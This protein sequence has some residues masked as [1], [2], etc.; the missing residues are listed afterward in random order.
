MSFPNINL[1]INLKPIFHICYIPRLF[2]W[3]LIQQIY[4]GIPSNFSNDFIQHELAITSAISHNLW[5]MRLR[6]SPTPKQL[7]SRNH[8][9]SY[10]TPKCWNPSNSKPNHQ[11]SFLS[12]TN[13]HYQLPLYILHKIRIIST[14]CCQLKAM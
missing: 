4:L 5:Q 14:F 9:S 3:Q 11:H 1:T 6:L 8:V 2:V 7:S 10:A 13:M 12:T